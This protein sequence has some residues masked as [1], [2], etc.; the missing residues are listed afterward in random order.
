MNKAPKKTGAVMRERIPPQP[1]RV[2]EW[3]AGDFGVKIRRLRKE[4]ALSLKDLSGLTGLS[5]ALISQVERGLNAPSMRSVRQLAAALGVSVQSLFSEVEEAPEAS[6]GI[7]VHAANRR[8]LNLGRT[9]TFLELLTP[10]GFQGLQ[11]FHSYIDPGASSGPEYD[12][13]LGT[14]SGVILAGCLDLWLDER[15]MRL[16]A[17]DSFSFQSE[18][19]HR[20]ENP[21]K[22]MTQVIWAVTPPIY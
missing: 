5:I 17:G 3:S 7:V 14:E 1:A 6:T 11:T 13:H 12:S 22:T 16:V 8:V 19:P 15:K 21:G 18:T 20:Y 2:E 10:K 9:G 4:R